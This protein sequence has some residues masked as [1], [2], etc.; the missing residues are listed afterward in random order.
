M[1]IDFDDDTL[2]FQ[3]EVRE[4]LAAHRESFQALS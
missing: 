1:D 2:T 4:F 3:Q